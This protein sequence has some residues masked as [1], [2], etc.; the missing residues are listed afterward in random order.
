MSLSPAF[1]SPNT[2]AG[3]LIVILGADYGGGQAMGCKV[4][5]GQ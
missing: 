3:F 5:V 2:H 4:W 1:L